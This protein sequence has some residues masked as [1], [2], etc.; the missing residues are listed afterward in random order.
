MVIDK[1]IIKN[2]SD[3]I[4]KDFIWDERTGLNERLN[5]ITSK[6]GGGKTKLLE[7]IAS[8]YRVNHNITHI[9]ASPQHFRCFEQIVEYSKAKKLTRPPESRHFTHLYPVITYLPGNKELIQNCNAFFNKLTLDISLDE[10]FVQGHRLLFNHPRCKDNNRLALSQLSTGEK[11]AFILWL[12]MHETQ[13]PDVL[14]LDEFDS[15]I[16]DDILDAFYGQLQML[17][18][19]CQIFITTNRWGYRK[20]LTENENFQWF[21]ID[22]GEITKGRPKYTK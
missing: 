4:L 14:L 20:D 15:T 8:K 16:N 13:K 2:H 18:K 1:I 19:E 3:N 10:G 11:T 17:S 21:T 12:M 5:I 6:N 9:S 22:D 7:Y